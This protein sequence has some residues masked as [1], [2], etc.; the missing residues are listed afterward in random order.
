MKFYWVINKKINN[1]EMVTSMDKI[2]LLYFGLQLQL[3]DK[4]YYLKGYF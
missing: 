2:R 3:E 1:L 4:K